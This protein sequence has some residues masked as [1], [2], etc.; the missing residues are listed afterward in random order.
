MSWERVW[1]E[2]KSSLILRKI[3]ATMPRV[4]DDFSSTIDFNWID[5]G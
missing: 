3:G 1:R 5:R 4:G 2:V